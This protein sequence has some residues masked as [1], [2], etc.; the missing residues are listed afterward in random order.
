MAPYAIVPVNA[1][2]PTAWNLPFQF[3]DGIHNSILISE[4]LDGF[5]VA[6]TRQNAGRAV[7]VCAAARARVAPSATAGGAN[8]R[9]STVRASVIVALGSVNDAKLSHG[10]AAAVAEA[11]ATMTMSVAAKRYFMG[12][13]LLS[14][15]NCR[16]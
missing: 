12:S 9:A 16:F 6:V 14:K 7:R 15:R 13:P 8:A 11:P 5:S 1:P 3:A 2:L 10:W 4:S